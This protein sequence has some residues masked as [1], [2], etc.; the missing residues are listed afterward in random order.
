VPERVQR[1]DAIDSISALERIGHQV[2][3]NDVHD[4]HFGLETFGDLVIKVAMSGAIVPDGTRYLG[5][6]RAVR[7]HSLDGS[8]DEHALTKRLSLWHPD[9]ND[10]G[11]R[12][13][14]PQ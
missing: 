14:E 7:R 12:R 8:V 11:S 5:A 2:A 6:N 4:L 9:T 3:Q 13:A 10:V 1:L